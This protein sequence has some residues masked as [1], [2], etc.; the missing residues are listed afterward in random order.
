MARTAGVILY[1]RSAVP[2]HLRSW[3]QLRRRWLLAGTVFLTMAAATFFGFL[4][5]VG[6]VMPSEYPVQPVAAERMASFAQGEIRYEERGDGDEALLLLHGFNAELGQWQGVWDLIGD[7]PGRQLRIDIPGFGA[8]RWTGH[9]FGLP[10]QASRI[11]ALLDR[12]GIHRVRIAGTSMG[13]SLAAWL[14]A[15]YPERVT[16]LV[17]FAP[18]GYPGSLQYSGMY[19]RLLR[20][21][22][23][24]DVAH[25]LSGTRLYALLMPHSRAGAA[26]SVTASYGEAWQ[27]A[28]GRIRAP[29]VIVWSTGDAT[30]AYG[31]AARQ[32]RA[33]IAGSELITLD[34]QAGHSIP[35][36]RP[37]LA[38]SI[39]RLRDAGVSPDQIAAR[40]PTEL[41][42]AGEH[43][44][45]T[46]D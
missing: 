22:L 9:H 29:T 2:L 32:V 37:Q 17:L 7:L 36:T 12:L 39:L 33:A 4:F 15:H 6:R 19:G 16:S 8:S 46:G 45:P 34:D 40:V 14:G 26:L 10:E 43:P 41:W 42:H 1:I 35:N 3:L 18:S 11:V 25:W 27:H 13:G 23:L 31:L 30:V 28:L 24:R 5:L 44:S 20:P 21:G 38:A